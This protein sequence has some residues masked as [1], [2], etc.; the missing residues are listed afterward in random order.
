MKNKLPKRA[1][2]AAACASVGLLL[3]ACGPADILPQAADGAATEGQLAGR[4]V[5]IDGDTLEIRGRRVRLHGIDAPELDQRCGSAGASW[6]CGRR[7]A[8]ALR[9]RIGNRPV[10]CRW[11]EIDPWNRPVAR[12]RAGDTDLSGWMVANGWAL[13]YRRYSLAY[14]AEEG[15]ARVARRGLWA[16][17]FVPP[18][19]HRAG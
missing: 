17:E 13:A 11:R 15:R 19:A 10:A 6:A 18:W 1:K 16:G 5:V 8:A 4:A 2:L 7:A 14:A 3:V 12:C 9:Q